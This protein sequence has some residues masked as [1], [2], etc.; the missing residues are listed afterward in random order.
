MI[1]VALA[2]LGL[3]Q[4]PL[5]VVRKHLETGELVSVLEAFEPERLNVYALWPKTAHLR[6]KVRCLIDTLIELGEAGR[7]N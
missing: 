2:G 7:L 6:P 4:M 1:D 3:C 5:C